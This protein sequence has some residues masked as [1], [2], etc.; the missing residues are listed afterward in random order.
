MSTTFFTIDLNDTFVRVFDIVF[1]M[2]N[3]IG[4]SI[5]SFDDNSL[6]VIIKLLVNDAITEITTSQFKRDMEQ[7]KYIHTIKELSKL[8]SQFSKCT[9][10]KPVNTTHYVPRRVNVRRNDNYEDKPQYTF[11]QSIDRPQQ[12]RKEYV[13]D[14]KQYSQQV[15]QFSTSN[16]PKY[17]QPQNQYNQPINSNIYTPDKNVFGNNTYNGFTPS[18]NQNVD[19]FRLDD[20]KSPQGATT[21]SHSAKRQ[22][23]ERI[24]SNEFTFN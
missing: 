5:K 1:D 20:T 17:N 2:K 7:G 24:P 11:S 23:I 6:C 4:V 19:G 10:H 14:Q 8:A 3:F 22:R 21:R 16:V 15:N 12:T 13:P 9:V 18:I